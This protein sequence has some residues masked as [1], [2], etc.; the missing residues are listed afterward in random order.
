MRT[1]VGITAAWVA[2]ALIDGHAFAQ[3]PAEP[4]FEVASV[5][6]GDPRDVRNVHDMSPGQYRVDNV[7]LLDIVAVAFGIPPERIDGAPDWVGGERY[8][9]TA[10]MPA[11]APISDRPKMVQALLVDRFKLRA[12]VEPREQSGYELVFAARDR[13]AG[14]QL[15]ASTIDC[16]TPAGSGPGDACKWNA[17]PGVFAATGV[18]AALLASYLSGQL[19]VPIVDH[20]QLQGTYDIS[21][22]WA[23]ESVGAPRGADSAATVN[24]APSVFVAL[25]EQLGLKLVS[26]TVPAPH[27]IVEHLEM[28]EPD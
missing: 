20:T 25:Q 24:D 13:R 9:V 19:G 1:A 23:R 4:R 18:P 10:R 2:V 6:R 21:L 8:S 15:V 27:V 12:R 22:T 5:K 26:A 7:S 17:R 28:P 11:G 16:V 3:V 14:K